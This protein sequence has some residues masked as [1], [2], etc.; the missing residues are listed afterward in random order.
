MMKNFG[1]IWSIFPK[2]QNPLNYFVNISKVLPVQNKPLMNHRNE[3]DLMN[4]NEHLLISTVKMFVQLRQD[5]ERVR[6]LTYMTLKREKLKKQIFTYTHDIFLK[7]VDYMK[8]YSSTAHSPGPS[9]LQ[10]KSINTINSSNLPTTTATSSSSSAVAAA[11]TSSINSR[12]REIMQTKSRGC[13][14]DFPEL[15]STNHRHQGKHNMSL[16]SNETNESSVSEPPS[17][18]A[19]IRKPPPRKTKFKKVVHPTGSARSEFVNRIKNKYKSIKLNKKK[20]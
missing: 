13:I 12:L 4:R 7:Q 3:Q 6:N 16:Q 2:N 18:V 14:Y 1:L 17:K 19:C 15:W 8:R 5:L 20:A 11:T 10:Q 9:V